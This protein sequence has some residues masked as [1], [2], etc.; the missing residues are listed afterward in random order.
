MKIELNERGKGWAKGLVACALLLAIAAFFLVVGILKRTAVAIVV[1][2]IGT[3][4]FGV[5]TVMMLNPNM[6]SCKQVVKGEMSY[7]ELKAAVEA[8]DFERPI[9]F[10]QKAGRPGLFLASDNWIVVEVHGNPVYVPKSKVRKI[11]MLMEPVEFGPEASG[12]G[13]THMHYYNYFVFICDEKHAFAT[14][15]IAYDDAS[16]A[17]RVVQEHFPHIPIVEVHTPKEWKQ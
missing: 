17:W 8:E 13:N 5:F 7:K 11:E 15:L 10:L 4:L 14:G 6:L 1:G 16:E 2:A 9:R 12:D 3:A